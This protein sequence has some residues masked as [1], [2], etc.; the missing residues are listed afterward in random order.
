MLLCT[1]YVTILNMH[2]LQTLTSTIE[3]ECLSVQGLTHASYSVQQ[4]TLV[5]WYANWHYCTGSVLQLLLDDMLD[6]AP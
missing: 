6:A 1:H 4:L 2:T 3:E 5:E